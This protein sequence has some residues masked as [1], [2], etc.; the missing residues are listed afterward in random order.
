MQAT[1]L[2]VLLAVASSEFEKTTHVIFMPAGKEFVGMLRTLRSTG[3]I[4]T[5]NE[6]YYTLTE[7]GWN[8]IRKQDIKKFKVMDAEI[9]KFVDG[10]K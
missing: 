4:E 5:L 9:D 1:K 2:E 8:Y 10:L 7:K 3:S 6:K